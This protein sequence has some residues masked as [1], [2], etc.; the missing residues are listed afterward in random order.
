M[1]EVLLLMM[2]VGLAAFSMRAINACLGPGRSM[3]TSMIQS[4]APTAAS[5]SSSRLPTL[6]RLAA[7]CVKRLAGLA[8]TMRS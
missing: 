6:T 7:L 2:A 1:P 4:L 5:K 8:L 3:I